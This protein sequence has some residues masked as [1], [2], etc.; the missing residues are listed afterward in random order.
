MNNIKKNRTRGKSYFNKDLQGTN[1]YKNIEPR[2]GVAKADGTGCCNNPNVGCGVCK[3]CTYTITPATSDRP[4]QDVWNSL[5]MYLAVNPTQKS[6]LEA[7]LK[8]FAWQQW[9]LN[10][11]S[12]CSTIKSKSSG[13]LIDKVLGIFR[14]LHLHGKFLL[15]EHMV[16]IIVLLVVA[17]TCTDPRT[18]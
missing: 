12:T 11:L 5:S 17:G 2:N 8:Q 3:G 7:V 16:N 4:T 9:F 6:N 15:L 18:C 13:T 14:L 1:I 10:L